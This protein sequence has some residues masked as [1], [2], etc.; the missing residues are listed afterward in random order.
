MN[1]RIISLLG[2]ASSGGL[3]RISPHMAVWGRR[4]MTVDKWHSL[5]AP[6]KVGS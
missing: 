2:S 6:W 3:K 1:V 4:A 5:G